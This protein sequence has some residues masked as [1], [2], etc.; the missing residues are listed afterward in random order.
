MPMTNTCKIM[1]PMSFK[2]P[3]EQT[4]PVQAA[5]CAGANG[6]QLISILYVCLEKV[7]SNSGNVPRCRIQERSYGTL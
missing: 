3:V 4:V 5:M 6:S 7:F 2:T 1:K